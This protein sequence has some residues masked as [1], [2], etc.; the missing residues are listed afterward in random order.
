MSISLF[1][2]PERILFG[3]GSVEKTG[4]E[5]LRYGNK[6][7]LVS[8]KSS[9]RTSGALT[10]VLAALAASG[11]EVTL[12]CEVESDPSVHTIAT[13]A[14]LARQTGASVIVALGGGSPLDAAK[15][16]ALMGL[17]IVLSNVW[18]AADS[19]HVGYAF[20]RFAPLLVTLDPC[21][22]PEPVTHKGQE[23]NYCLEGSMLVASS[24]CHSTS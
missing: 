5:A 16:I 3:W 24:C 11:I 7:L 19:G 12:F 13:G 21:K 20:R 23:F 15:A 6:A 18:Q 4:E 8:G 17:P 10:A 2:S 1:L 9:S 14:A 22:S